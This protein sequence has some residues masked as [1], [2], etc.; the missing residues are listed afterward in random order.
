MPVTLVVTCNIITAQLETSPW[1]SPLSIFRGMNDIHSQPEVFVQGPF[2]VIR[3]DVDLALMYDPCSQLSLFLARVAVTHA[4]IYLHCVY[5]CLDPATRMC[6]GKTFLLQQG[7]SW[8]NSPG[9]H[10]QIDPALLS[11][12]LI[13]ESLPWVNYIQRY[14]AMSRSSVS[15]TPSYLNLS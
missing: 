4:C 8:E 10:I 14:P 6:W 9:N 5:K 2:Q 11:F 13:N 15:T 7:L 3:V 1:L 12:F